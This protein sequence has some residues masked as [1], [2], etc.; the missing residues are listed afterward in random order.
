MLFFA[1]PGFSDAARAYIIHILGIT[2]QRVS[3]AVLGAALQ[4]QGAE[5][6]KLVG[7]S[8][9]WLCNARAHPHTPL[10]EQPH[11]AGVVC[12]AHVQLCCYGCASHTW[13]SWHRKQHVTLAQARL[14]ACCSQ[15]MHHWYSLMLL[16]VC[17]VS[18]QASVRH[19]PWQS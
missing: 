16:S 14:M 1:V 17:D 4:L 8:H 12:V 11:A 19:I 10:R 15:R 5:L 7:A 2:Y 18:G 6:D 13:W 9:G 3:K